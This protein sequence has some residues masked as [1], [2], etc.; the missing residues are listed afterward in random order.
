[1]SADANSL[2]MMLPNSNGLRPI[3]LLVGLAAAVAVGV[4]VA[5]WSKEPDYSILLTRVGNSE[6]AQVIS[7]LQSAS[8]PYKTDTGSGSVSVPTS[9]LSEARLKLAGEGLPGE[10]GFAALTKDTGYGTSQLMENT[11]YKYALELELA[12][13][14]ASLDSVA[15]ARVHLAIPEQSAFVRDKR[16]AS[17]SVLVQLKNGRRLESEQVTSIINLIASSVPAMSATDVTVIDQ[18]GRLL[19][20]PE[21]TDEFSLRDKQ[22]EFAHHLEETYISRIEELLTPLVGA[23]NVRAQVTADVVLAITEESREQYNPQGQV[24]RSEQTTE[25][26]TRNGT[27]AQGVP[28]SLT[29]QPPAAGAAA[30]PNAATNQVAGQATSAASAAS[31]SSDANGAPQSS[32]KESTR[33]YEVDRTLAYTKQLPG[34]LKR[35]SVAVLV[36]NL[37]TTDADGKATTTP[38]TPEQ[39]E[40]ITR[41]VKDAVG[42]DEK[43]GDSVNVV[44]SAFQPTPAK[45]EEELLSVPLWERPWVIDLTKLLAGVGVLLVL[46]L[47]V[48]KPLVRSVITPAPLA[49]LPSAAVAELTNQNQAAAARAAASV[50]LEEQIA[51]A[52]SLVSQD[53]ARVAQVV[54]SW[55]EKG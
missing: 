25:Q 38:L 35:L 55:V 8:I 29:N 51:Q 4:G 40:N 2:P 36:D 1:M 7:S 11:K 6:I 5:L 45:A 41:L 48:I 12:K 22:Y 10:G 27:E 20:S 47:S 13:T 54:N 37:K 31:A 15:S 21:G 49:P 18:S 28:G 14:V 32:N 46:I 26:L 53:P 34:Q 39:I 43:R 42:Y 30:K 50:G 3:L 24:L 44:N 19:S 16:K 23:G 33:N 17:A 52:K 9:R